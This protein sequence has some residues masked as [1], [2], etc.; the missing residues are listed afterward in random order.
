MKSKEGYKKIRAWLDEEEAKGFHLNSC[1]IIVADHKAK[2][3][4]CFADTAK[5]PMARSL[6]AL[7]LDDAVMWKAFKYANRLA[8]QEQRKKK[9]EEENGGK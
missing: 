6:A 3:W 5:E 1:C 8:L 9:K 7:F 2:T 4:S